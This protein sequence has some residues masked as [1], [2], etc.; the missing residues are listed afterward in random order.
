MYHREERLVAFGRPPAG[1]EEGAGRR[2]MAVI[3]NNDSLAEQKPE[4]AYTYIYTYMSV[5]IKICIDRGASGSM[6]GY[7]FMRLSDS[8]NVFPTGLKSRVAYP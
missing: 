2:L 8:A 6:R 1:R 4:G 7:I 3:K 5:Y